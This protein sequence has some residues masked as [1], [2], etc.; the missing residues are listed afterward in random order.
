MVPAERRDTRRAA[1]AAALLVAG[2]R[3]G[4]RRLRAAR[5]AGRRVR[6]AG[7]AGRAAE[8]RIGRFGRR[9]ACGREARRSAGR[10]G[11]YADDFAHSQIERAIAACALGRFDL[12]NKPR[13]R[14]D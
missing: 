9:A 6:I 11:V 4:R 5:R 7:R 14:A 8:R 13:R 2:L 3:A 10:V 1:P 12:G